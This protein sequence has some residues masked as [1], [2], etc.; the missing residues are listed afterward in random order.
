MSKQGTGDNQMQSSTA[1]KHP[2]TSNRRNPV[3]TTTLT[4]LT[5]ALV[6]II[7][8]FASVTLTP[9]GQVF[10]AGDIMIFITAFTFGPVVGGLAGGVGSGLSDFFHGGGGL[11]F[12]PFTAII[13]GAEGFIAGYIAQKSLRGQELRLGWLAGSIVMVTGYFLAEY[14]FIGLVFGGDVLAGI[15]PLLDLPFNL[16]Q[17][18]AGGI[19]GIPV[20]KSLKKALPTTLFSGKKLS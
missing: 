18:A 19:I 12:A 17:V 6:L 16:L 3:V 8:Y 15:F 9:Q 11:Y 1:E 4:A 20:S 2:K 7:T 14:Y 13:K 10:D 5:S